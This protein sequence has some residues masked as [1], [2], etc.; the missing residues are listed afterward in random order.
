MEALKVNKSGKSKSKE[1]PKAIA[2]RL[3]S[4]QAAHHG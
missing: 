2:G 4:C 3:N 1:S